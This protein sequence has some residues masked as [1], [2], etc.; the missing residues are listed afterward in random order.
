MPE[1]F[2]EGK[3]LPRRTIPEMST[4]PAPIAPA[5]PL[6][7]SRESLLLIAIEFRLL[8]GSAALPPLSRDTPMCPRTR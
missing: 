4:L 3:T 1:N 7:P 6:L 2:P 5:P 8:G